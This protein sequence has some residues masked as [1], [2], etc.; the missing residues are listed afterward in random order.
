MEF[1]ESKSLLSSPKHHI[2]NINR[3]E[4]SISLLLG[5]ALAMF[6]LQRRSRGGLLLA[7][8]GAELIRRG[9]T[10]RCYLYENLGVRTAPK[11]QGAEGTSLPYELGIRVDRAITVNKPRSEVYQFWRNLENLPRFTK[12]LIS[13]TKL[14]ENRSHWVAK[15]PAGSKVEW[16]ASIINESENERIAWRSLEGSEIQ[17]A[18]A[19]VFQDAPA[20]RGTKVLVHLQYNPPAGNL[21]AA[22]AKLLGE[23]P[24][25]QIEED[26][27]RFRQLMETGEIMTVEGQPS[28]RTARRAQPTPSR[29]ERRDEQRKVDEM[30]EQSF[31]AS[32]SPAY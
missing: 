32:D 30:S 29:K 27:H 24:H 18:G 13:V 21:G 28:G 14:D 12:H 23:E 7:A 20:G 6:G 16:D 10:G 15:G 5:G 8:F 31:P 4:R 19:V 11:G 26:L 1:T 17:N 2:V 3:T 22:V 9:T 25:Q